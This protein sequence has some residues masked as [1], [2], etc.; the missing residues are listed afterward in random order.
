M[1]EQRWNQDFSYK[2]RQPSKT[3]FC[4]NVWKIHEIKQ[5]WVFVGRGALPD[6]PISRATGIVC[7]SLNIYY[8]DGSRP[9]LVREYQNCW[10]KCWL[11]S[12]P[13]L[14]FRS[15]GEHVTITH[16]TLDLT[17]QGHLPPS[18]SDMGPHPTGPPSLRS[19]HLVATVQSGQYVPY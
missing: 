8:P 10:S 18:L 2:G 9:F 15:Q 16:D 4:Q 14:L 7:L 1:Q 5:I 11:L 6:P 13:F 17:V 3:P 12:Q 19:W